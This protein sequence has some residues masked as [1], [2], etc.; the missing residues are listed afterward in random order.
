MRHMR[1]LITVS[2]LACLSCLNARAEG[3]IYRFHWQGGDG[4]TM[5]GALSF[6]P[7]TPG[8]IIRDS[9]VVCFFI[10]GR[11]EGALIGRWD[12]S[13]LHPGSIWRLHFDA[14][15]AAFLVEGE[16]VHMPQAW[17]MAG[18]GSGCGQDGFGF[19]LGNI[20]QDLCVDDKVIIAS[21]V[22][23]YAPFGA[24]RDDAFRFPPGSCKAPP[25]LSLLHS[26]AAT[27]HKGP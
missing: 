10:E 11:D 21:Q 23:P 25:M 7:A 26:P 5:D 8:P 3:P 4:Y 16:G 9:D 12:M 24:T 20:A 15:R 18:S 22:D 14:G 27:D 6:D 19:N 2:L 17:N 13:M 1:L